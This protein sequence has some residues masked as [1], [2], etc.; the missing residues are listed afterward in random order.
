MQEVISDS[1]VI[2]HIFSHEADL[3]LSAAALC[4]CLQPT[5]ESSS[6]LIIQPFPNW[7]TVK[8]DTKQK[9]FPHLSMAIFKV[10]GNDTAYK[11]SA[12]VAALPQL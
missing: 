11:R 7:F 8:V 4:S 12:G 2:F 9:V 10:S 5:D 1:E 3:N 6:V